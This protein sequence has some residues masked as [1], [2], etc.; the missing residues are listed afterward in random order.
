MRHHQQ[1]PY[2]IASVSSGGARRELVFSRFKATL[3]V[4]ESGGPIEP[5]IIAAREPHSRR[6]SAHD[7]DVPP[8]IISTSDRLTFCAARG[9]KGRRGSSHL[10]WRT[11]VIAPEQQPPF[12]TCD[13]LP[14]LRSL[15]IWRSRFWPL[16]KQSWRQSQQDAQSGAPS[17][18]EA[19]RPTCGHDVCGELQHSP[20]FEGSQR[21]GRVRD[22]EL[23]EN[24]STSDTDTVE[25]KKY[26]EDHEWVEL[27]ADG[28]TGKHS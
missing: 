11:R 5:D 23:E 15:H 2:L 17:L 22:V 14:S 8:V 26:T 16:R 19:S 28:K 20:P 24:E 12:P 6:F 7:L 9:R 4:S 3:S 27:D 13:F 18:Q 1:V 10:L 21:A 25:V